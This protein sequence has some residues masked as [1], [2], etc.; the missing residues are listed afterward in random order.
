MQHRFDD[1]HD[2]KPVKKSEEYDRIKANIGLFNWKQDARKD[3]K[4]QKKRSSADDSDG[5]LSLGDKVL[6]FFLCCGACSD[7]KP[8][9]DDK[10]RRGQAPEQQSSAKRQEMQRKI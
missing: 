5:E 8:K 6:R 7:D 10:N 9:K 1:L 2:C 4:R 3:Q